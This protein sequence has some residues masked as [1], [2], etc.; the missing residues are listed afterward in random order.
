MKPSNIL[1]SLHDGKAVPKVIDFGIAKATISPLT[2]HTLVTGFGAVVGTPEYMSPEQADF[3]A[4][5]VDTRSDVYALGILLYE[6]LTG[7][8]PVDRKQFG[9][10]ALLE[11]LRIVREVEPPRP[12]TRLSVDA[13]LPDIAARRST[14]PRTLTKIVRGDLDCIVMKALEKERD[15]R[16]ESASSLA[17]DIERYLHH[18]TVEARPQSI[19]YRLRKFVRR[20]RRAVIVTSIFFVVF[21]VLAVNLHDSDSR[22]NEMA[23]LEA[24]Q[25]MEAFQYLLFMEENLLG[26]PDRGNT[27]RPLRPTLDRA[28]DSLKDRQLVPL[29]EARLRTVIGRA[30]LDM[31]V[32]DR[33]EV[34][35]T[36]ALDL[37][38]SHYGTGSLGWNEFD[39]RVKSNLA[40]LHTEVGRHD[41]AEPMLADEVAYYRHRELEGSAGLWKSRSEGP[42]VSNYIASM[43]SL[44]ECYMEQSRF[45]DAE[46]L[47]TE[48]IQLCRS[49]RK[50]IMRELHLAWASGDHAR[51]LIER[52]AYAEA[53]GELRECLKNSSWRE[54]NDPERA[55][56]ALRLGAA[57]LG[58]KKYAEAEPQLLKAYEGFKRQPG[59]GS[60]P[61]G[62]RP[63]HNLDLL[64]ELYTAWGKPEEAARWKSE[65][66]KGVPQQEGGK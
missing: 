46:K 28:A 36:K 49:D 64:V 25:R 6:M 17:R 39:M 58:Q 43:V 7:S 32:Y 18:E 57:L 8:P 51:C 4:Q 11:I 13:A 5:D 66:A 10:A 56:L 31:R 34:Q 22:A 12:S 24:V 54:A 48:A 21:S 41:Q 20:N 60:A 16:Y 33:A 53:E 45:A 40:R 26:G 52:K 14:E 47:L 29:T 42:D 65:R 23:Q 61:K 9:R 50:A 62:R 19:A 59:T 1:V 2:E 30:Y 15:R 63:A 35:L 27:N 3:D 55:T 38:V 44:S 37:Y